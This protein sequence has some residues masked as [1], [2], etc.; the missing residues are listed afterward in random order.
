MASV[1][2]Q[3]N[4]ARQPG[5]YE[6]GKAGSRALCFECFRVEILRRQAVASRLT[7]QWNAQQVTLPLEEKMRALSLRRRHAQI[8]ARHVLG[9]R[10]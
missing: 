2:R 3:L 1:A 8:A 4:S 6:M 7:R 10:L 9:D 5:L